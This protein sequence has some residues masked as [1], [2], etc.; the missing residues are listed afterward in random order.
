MFLLDQDDRI[1]AQDNVS[2]SGEQPQKIGHPGRIEGSSRNI[3]SDLDLITQ[4][5]PHIHEVNDCL[6]SFDA[7][8]RH[9]FADLK[10]ILP[11]GDIV[12]RQARPGLRR[13]RDGEE[14][15]AWGGLKEMSRGCRAEF[16]ANT[17]YRRPTSRAKIARRGSGWDGSAWSIGGDDWR[18]PRGWAQECKEHHI[19][20]L[21]RCISVRRAIPG[22]RGGQDKATAEGGLRETAGD[23]QYQSF[24]P[25]DIHF[26]M[27]A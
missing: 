5:L 8:A 21:T 13:R 3:Q 17:I 4:H 15:T 7:H 26:E 9:L 12:V 14:I 24:R 10:R 20:A 16:C 1:L 22:L 27:A 25:H 6:I 11:Q 19:F 23:G 18:H 2:P